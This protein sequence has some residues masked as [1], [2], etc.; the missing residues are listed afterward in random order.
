MPI[1]LKKNILYPEFP[2]KVLID[3][4]GVIIGKWKG[5]GE[6][7]KMSCNKCL[8]RYLIKINGLIEEC[9]NLLPCKI[10]N[11]RKKNPATV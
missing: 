1:L 7:T 10:K 3:K 2:Y 9:T 11:S 5:V 4:N 8:L 6:K